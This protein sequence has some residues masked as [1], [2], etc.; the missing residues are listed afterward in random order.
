MGPNQGIQNFSYYADTFIFNHATSKWRQVLT[1]GF[2]THRAQSHL[3]ADPDSGKTY[4]VGGYTN[5]EWIQTRKKYV[6]RSFDDIW[7]LSV[8]EEGGC[9]EAGE[10]E[11]DAKT[12]QAG[13]W[14]RCFAC[15]AVGRTQKCG[16]KSTTLIH[17]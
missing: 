2:P 13:P 12:A 5:L 6:S 4:L 10:F 8:D 1:R 14:K 3:L 11:A 7:R 9:Y 16:G 15:G 17:I